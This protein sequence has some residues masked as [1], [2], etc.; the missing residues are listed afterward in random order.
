MDPI[1]K[2]MAK[3][4]WHLAQARRWDDF[5]KMMQELD[6]DPDG[7]ARQEAPQPPQPATKPQ[8]EKPPGPLVQRTRDVAIAILQ[9]TGKPL[10]REEML[11]ALRAR[12]ITMPGDDP[13]GTLYGR[14]HKAPG[15][16]L[17]RGIGWDLKERAA[18]GKL[19]L[20]ATA[21]PDPGE[22]PG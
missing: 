13:P 18:A 6:A 5:L 16:V 14:L 2:A 19:P 17:I 7:D 22:A 9:E 11:E 21:E 8:Q 3:R 12:G 20:D 15:I 4:G 1:E 10:G